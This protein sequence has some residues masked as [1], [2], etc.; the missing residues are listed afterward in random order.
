[1]YA[2]L[3]NTISYDVMPNN[4]ITP[5]ALHYTAMYYYR[6]NCNI[7]SVNNGLFNSELYVIRTRCVSHGGV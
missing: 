4:I 6:V 7:I 5:I 3:L 2:Y 1:M